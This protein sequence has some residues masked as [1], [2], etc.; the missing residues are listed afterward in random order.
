M[1]TVAGGLV[2][3]GGG[4]AVFAARSVRSDASS[5]GD[6]KETAL[7]YGWAG[8][9]AAVVGV[10]LGVVGAILWAGDDTSAT[11]Q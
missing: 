4:A 3:V 11:P 7:M 1:L 10:G 6:A 5:S 8:V 2:A 9:G